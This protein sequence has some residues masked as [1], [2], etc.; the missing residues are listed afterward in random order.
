MREA[1]L[2]SPAGSRYDVS[3][4]TDP[5]PT[6]TTHASGPSTATASDASNSYREPEKAQIRRPVL[7]LT[8][9]RAAPL[10]PIHE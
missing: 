8:L 6:S 9:V 3:S 5:E 2:S 1:S 7:A 4:V 10:S